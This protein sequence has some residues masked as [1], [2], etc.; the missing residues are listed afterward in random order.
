MKRTVLCLALCFVLCCPLAHADSKADSLRVLD[1]QGERYSFSSILQG[2]SN[3][4]LIFW[5]PWCAS[6]KKEAPQIEKAAKAHAGKIQFFGVVSGPDEFVDDE[7]VSAFTKKYELTYPQ[8]RDRKLVLTDTFKVK[9]TPTIVILG[10]SGD[11]LYDG[12]HAP[13]EW[14]AF[15]GTQVGA[16]REG[17]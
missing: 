12:H 2:G 6:C 16:S 14:E 17:R 4:A 11:M 8:I 7:K 15:A 3:I 13:D 9:S 1:M 10:A 5:Q